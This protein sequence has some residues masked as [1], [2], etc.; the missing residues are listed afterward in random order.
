[1]KIKKSFFISVL[2][3]VLSSYSLAASSL[4]VDREKV[5]RQYIIALGYADADVISDLFTEDAIVIT[6]SQGKVKA[7]EFFYFFL[8]TLESSS[9][10]LHQVF[11]NKIKN[12][13][14]TARFHFK[15]KL[16]NG[17]ATEGEYMDEFLFNQN[18]AQLKSVYMFENLKFD[19]E[20]KR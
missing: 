10:E 2:L 15:Y 18:S 3:I 1:M 12:G 4:E 17:E 9:T 19:E 7:K 6:T 8:P 13:P 14:Y 20:G 11:I 5:V 16:K